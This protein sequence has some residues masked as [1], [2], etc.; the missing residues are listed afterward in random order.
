MEVGGGG[1]QGTEA[2]DFMRF[3]F[4]MKQQRKNGQIFLR[5]AVFNCNC[6]GFAG[7]QLRIRNWIDVMEWNGHECKAYE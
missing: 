4:Q 2:R 7:S 6:P 3:A 1:L 5:C